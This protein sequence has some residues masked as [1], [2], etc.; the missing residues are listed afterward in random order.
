MLRALFVLRTKA[1]VLENLPI[2]DALRQSGWDCEFLI[3]PQYAEQQVPLIIEAGFAAVHPSGARLS[4]LEQTG[5]KNTGESS[6]ELIVKKLLRIGNIREMIFMTLPAVVRFTLHYHSRVR[7]M[8]NFLQTRK[9]AIVLL[10]GDRQ[11]GWELACIKAAKEYGIATLITPYAIQFAE[12]IAVCR[13]RRSDYRQRFL[14][15]GVVRS[16]VAKFFPDWTFVYRGQRMLYY[17]VSESLAAHFLGLMPKKPWT[18]GGG[19]VDFMAVES[20]Y[21]RKIFLEDGVSADH[22][23]VTGKPC[24]DSIA[25]PMDTSHR[26]EE[27]TV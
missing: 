22:M 23:V 12:G 24:N 11:L 18:V 14:V 16:I 10:S 20:A 2:A 19:D 3:D 4:L 8:R 15:C 5:K 7:R 17:P 13:V 26:S 1:A 9:P 27:H 25:I 21:A 6:E